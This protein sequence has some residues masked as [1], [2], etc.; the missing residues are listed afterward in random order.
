[1]RTYRKK[2]RGTLNKEQLQELAFKDFLGELTEEE[3][4]IAKKYG[5][6]QWHEYVQKQKANHG[7]KAE[8][9]NQARPP[10]SPVFE[11]DR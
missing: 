2:I 8:N 9:L 6:Y 3:I 11:R 10:S 1:M 5:V 7:Q 4:P